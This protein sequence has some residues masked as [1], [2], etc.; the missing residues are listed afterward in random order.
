MFRLF[1]LFSYSLTTHD[2]GINISLDI[3]VHIHDVC[4]TINTILEVKCMLEF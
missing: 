1:L 2:A 3:H 4:L